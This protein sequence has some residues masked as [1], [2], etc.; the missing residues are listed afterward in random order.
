MLEV[1]ALSKRFGGLMAVRDI[2]LSLAE[3]EILGLIGPNGA[4]KTT[5]F[6]CV[7]GAMAPSSGRV[8]IQGEDV[9]GQKAHK[10]CRA[11]IGRTYQIV[12]PFAGLTVRDNVMVG[13]INRAGSLAEARRFTEE[14]LEITGLAAIGGDLASSLPL[15]RRKRLEVAR[16]LATRPKVLLLDEVMAGLNPSEVER[17]VLLIRAIRDSGI[18][19]L[20]IEHLMRVIMAVSDRIV[21]M[22]HGEKLA[23]GAPSAVMS[24]PRVVKAYLGEGFNA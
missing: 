22:H 23:E 16:A 9:T 18:S 20:I 3:G 17:A 10:V 11:G 21:V 19:V 8:R 13:A 12:K 4:G 5:F 14:A 15:P 24:D 1:E 2:S 7:A 6:N